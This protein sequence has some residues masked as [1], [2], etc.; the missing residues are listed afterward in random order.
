[1]ANLGDGYEKKRNNA[2]GIRTIAFECDVVEQLLDGFY[3][4]HFRKFSE[5][6]FLLLQYD[7]YDHIY[8]ISKSPSWQRSILMDFYI[9]TYISL[10]L[11]LCFQMSEKK[12]FFFLPMET[13]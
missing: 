12:L 4:K 10:L 9:C 2:A 7:F 6:F 8:F 1:M 3:P 11:I 13:V 5:T